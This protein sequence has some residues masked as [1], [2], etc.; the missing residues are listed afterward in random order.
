MYCLAAD[1]KTHFLIFT[2]EVTANV[3][4]HTVDTLPD[5]L[6]NMKYIEQRVTTVLKF[7]NSWDWC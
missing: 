1:I 2:P 4:Y 3:K 7:S 5:M 6:Q